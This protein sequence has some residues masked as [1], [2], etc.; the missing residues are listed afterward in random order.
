M[1]L[2]QN[3]L[4]ATL[5]TMTNFESMATPIP[6]PKTFFK[7][8]AELVT[9][10]NGSSFGRGFPQA[11]MRWNILTRAQ[12]D[13]LRTYCTGASAAVFVKLRTNDDEDEYKVFQGIMHWVEEEE[14]DSRARVD[15]T[16]RFTH[17]IEQEV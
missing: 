1:P 13:Q 10:G 5:A 6:N 4:G 17:L 14:K 11:E 8:Y 9:L 3:E 12:R 2:Y 16:L 7:P 15:F